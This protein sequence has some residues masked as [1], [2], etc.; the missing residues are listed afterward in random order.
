V[1]LF[2]YTI[3]VDDGAAPNPFRGLCTL[4]ICKPGIRSAASKGDWVAGLGSRNAPSGDLSRRLVYAMRVSEVVTM[5]DYDRLAPSRWPSRIPNIV[6]NDLSERLGDCLYDFSAAS[7]RQRSGVHDQ[8]NQPTDLRGKNVLVS[9]HFYYFGAKAI[10]L[11]AP[12]YPICHQ[13]QG[14]RS[15]LNDPY[16]ESFISWISSLKLTPGQL[17]GWPDYIVDW[18]KSAGCGC[19]AREI[20]G[21]NDQPRS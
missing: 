14:H 10:P 2:T 1:R 8:G 17:Y 18:G 13:R 3:P 16:V 20:D 5:P 6:S 15:D 12:L 19:R 11:P 9:T 4:A 7:P 21:E